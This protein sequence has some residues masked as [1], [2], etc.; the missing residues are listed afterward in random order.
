MERGGYLRGCKRKGS[1]P[2]G[3]LKYPKVSEQPVVVKIEAPD[4]DELS[5]EPPVLHD[6]EAE[7]VVYPLGETCISVPLYGYSWQIPYVTKE[8]PMQ[9]TTILCSSQSDVQS[10]ASQVLR[11]LYPASSANQESVVV[12]YGE[13]VLEHARQKQ[14]VNTCDPP[15][16]HLKFSS[17]S[18]LVY[19][20]SLNCGEGAIFYGAYIPG[21]RDEYTLKRQSTR[22]WLSKIYMQF[23]FGASNY[24]VLVIDHKKACRKV[25]TLL[26]FVYQKPGSSR[27]N[28]L[29]VFRA[30]TQDVFGGDPKQDLKFEKI[31][32]QED[33]VMYSVKSCPQSF[34]MVG[35]PAIPITHDASI[36]LYDE[37]AYDHIKCYYCVPFNVPEVWTSVLHQNPDH[38]AS[39]TF[40]GISVYYGQITECQKPTVEPVYTQK[41]KSP[42]FKIALQELKKEAVQRFDQGDGDDFFSVMILFWSKGIKIKNTLNPRLVVLQ[43]F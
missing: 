24:I 33:L 17:T 2:E 26:D 25:Q 43:V 21:E 7:E 6:Q 29:S 20:F 28:I 37:G 14:K 13:S 5:L 31:F 39:K 32:P 23:Y 30:I 1:T 8:P 12:E 16:E 27:T 10:A 40:K 36:G 15:R 34:D 18:P 42:T 38:F 4:P 3:A 35:Q 11:V 19:N 22:S 9:T 41:V